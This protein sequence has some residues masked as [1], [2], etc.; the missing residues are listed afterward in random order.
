MLIQTKFISF[1][2]VLFLLASCGPEQSRDALGDSAA[3]VNIVVDGGGPD[4]SSPSFE[5]TI[6]AK[7]HKGSSVVFIIVDAFNSSHTSAYGYGRPT[8]PNLEK[9]ARRG[10]LFTNW[11]S[12]SSWTRPSFTTLITGLPKKDHKVE[13]NS[14][15][16]SSKI[17]TIAEIFRDAGYSTA[18]FV[19]NPLVRKVWLFDQG[20]KVYEDTK[21]HKA[22]PRAKIL[23]DKAIGWLQKATRKDRPFFLM[24]FLT[25]PHT[26]Y[27]PV[28]RHRNYLEKIGKKENIEYPFKEY[29]KP[30]PKAEH[31]AIVAAY[32]GEVAYADEQI[33]S[34]IAE[35]ET[36][37][38]F[39]DTT[40][41][42]TADHGEIF[43]E[44]NCYLH[45]YH[46]WEPVLRVPFII[47]SP[48]L[49]ATGQVNDRP[50]THMDLLPSLANLAG[51]DV[52]GNKP[53]SS[54]LDAASTAKTNADRPLFS[55]YNAH[56]IERQ[57]AR[58][59]R[60]KL[61]HHHHVNKRDLKKLG[62]LSRKIPRADPRDLPSIAVDGERWELYDLVADP[63][64]TND[65]YGTNS[66]EPV[67][68]D[69]KEII[70]RF[71]MDDSESAQPPRLS[72]ETIEAL[73][74]AGYIK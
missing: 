41:V 4:L 29:K 46:M 5:G 62:G 73:Q 14:Q 38:R 67:V 72:E 63:A 35:L 54:I 49:P 65:L 71:R 50:H 10:T 60:W 52:P 45:G 69:L 6:P 39:D 13:L 16:L 44:H 27:R 33:G 1:S 58:I 21:D 22:F 17:V 26:P 9:L 18:G 32:D 30:L 64:E 7:I 42:V 23:V 2:I 74:A 61:I 59:G 57:A 25:D 66:H 68:K 3:A 20:F 12:N 53:G 47:S 51:I 43:G 55:Q 70:A 56:G 11:V 31:E 24:I 48:S 15:N 8:T 19:G 28:T 36:L 34:L 40:V 37:G